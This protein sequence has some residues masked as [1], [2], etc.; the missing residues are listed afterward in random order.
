MAMRDH[1]APGSTESGA[2][3]NAEL[4][5]L[6]ALDMV[7]PPKPNPLKRIWANLWPKLLAV[8]IALGIWQFVVW[9]GWKPEYVLPPPGPVFRSLWDNL[10]VILQ[11]LGNTMRR[12]AIGFTLALVI[13]VV[14]GTL[15]SQ[16]RVLR[17][18]IGSMITGLQ[19]MPSIVWF[20]L[21]FVLFPYSDSAV[22]FVVVLGAAPSIANG[23]IGGIDHIQ[24]VL[25][26][27]G[28]VLG[29]RG[30][31]NL[32]YVVLPA[33]LPSFVGGLK[34]G[35]AFAWRSLL[36]GELLLAASGKRTIGGLL[37]VNRQF[38]DYAGLMAVMIVILIIGLVIDSIFGAFDKA[39]RR[40]YGL[41]DAAAQ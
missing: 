29:A 33:A 14:L 17:A 41:I 11:G 3:I 36:A 38:S 35:W 16:S 40:R 22:Y 31:A 5:G 8:G 34:Q 26:R 18:G 13:G 27:A 19:T 25:L 30:F 7:L 28:R 1:V 2:E 24:P 4:S 20:P 10:D 12:A 37:E 32:R 6:D 21:A 39:I 23:I 9:T 15:V